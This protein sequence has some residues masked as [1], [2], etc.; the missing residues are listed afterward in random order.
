MRQQDDEENQDQLLELE[1]LC[2]T[3]VNNKSEIKIN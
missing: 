1:E 2:S 3:D